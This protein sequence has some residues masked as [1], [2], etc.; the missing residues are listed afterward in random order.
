MEHA[1]GGLGKKG[2]KW[3]DPSNEGKAAKTYKEGAKSIKEPH[4]EE[5]DENSGR[6]KSEKQSLSHGRIRSFPSEEKR[7]AASEERILVLR[8]VHSK[9]AWGAVSSSEIGRLGRKARMT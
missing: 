5:K 3:G 4:E 6:E 9:N 8:R 1:L 7:M 2:Q